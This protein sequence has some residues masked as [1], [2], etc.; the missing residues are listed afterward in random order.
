VIASLLAQSDHIIGWAGRKPPF[1]YMDWWPISVQF[2]CG[3]PPMDNPKVRWAVAYAVNQQQVVDTGWGG[4]GLVSNTIFPGFK[5][6]TEYMD[7]IK[8]ITDK[9]NVL[10]V[11]LDKSTQLMTE[12][13]Y[14]K[15]ADGFWADSTGARQDFSI[16]AAVPLFAD[17]APVVA[18]QLRSAGFYC[19]HK[20]PADVWAAKVDG[21]AT[22]FLFGH[23]GSTVDPLDTFMLYR[24]ENIQPMGQQS[25]GNIT[26]WA[27]DEFTALTDQINNTPMDD[28]KMKELFHSAMEIWYRELPDCPLVQWFHRIPMNTTY[29]DNWPTQDNPYMNAALWHQTALIVVINLKAKQA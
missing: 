14:A 6:L 29:W 22:L 3:R 9:Y 20:A 2:C 15:D 18:E 4:A 10:E 13:G 25:W 23:G 27:N 8:D 28:P 7:G 21:R 17:I 12:A 19:E 11:N 24:K 16:Y 5:K 26:R 1:G